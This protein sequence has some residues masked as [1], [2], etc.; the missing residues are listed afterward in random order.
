[1]EEDRQAFGVRLG[2]KMDLEE[3]FWY[4][5]TFGPVC[6]EFPDSTF[7]ERQK[8]H[9]RNYLTNVTDLIDEIAD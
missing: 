1:M 2:E 3:T 5:V 9:L 4:P 8:N 7:R 6:L